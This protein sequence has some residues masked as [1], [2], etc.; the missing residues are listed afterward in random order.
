M[1]GV[2]G[3]A[4]VGEGAGLAGVSPMLGAGPAMVYLMVT[5]IGD[6][7]PLTHTMVTV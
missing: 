1:V 4:E 6:T 5:L 3:L 7:D 2:E